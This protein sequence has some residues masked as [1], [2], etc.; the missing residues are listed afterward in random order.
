M[1]PN[2]KRLIV[3][4]Q[5]DLYSIVGLMEHHIPWGNKKVDWPVEIKA[6]GSAPE[7]L[8]EGYI[9]T[10]LTAS[11]VENIGIV[12]DANGH[13]QAR[14]DAIRKEC[15][16]AFPEMPV[17]LPSDGLVLENADK[18]RIGVWIMPNNVAIGMMETFLSYLVR[19]EH[20]FIWK[21]AKGIVVEVMKNGAPVRECHLDKANI[22]TWL[23]WQDPPG[24]VLG[25]ALK[26]RILDPHSPHAAAFVAWF[27]KLFQV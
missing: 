9:A 8:V 3:E 11:G 27:R 22:H 18:K 15:I 23:A 5:D 12:I 10:E 14:W 17:G 13:F 4:G 24:E 1:A 2:K 6:A 20:E 26:Q 21:M 25:N 7:M 19:D 16:D